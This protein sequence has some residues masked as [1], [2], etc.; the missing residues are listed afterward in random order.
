MFFNF[1]SYIFFE[2]MRISRVSAKKCAFYQIIRI[3]SSRLSCN[4]T[5]VIIFFFFTHSFELIFLGQSLKFELRGWNFKIDAQGI[6]K[7]RR[8]LE[9]F[10][11]RSLKPPRM[12]ACLAANRQYFVKENFKYTTSENEYDGSLFSGRLHATVFTKPAVT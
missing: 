4:K 11:K 2:K 8:S 9:T 3:L 12:G 5:L 7:I 6:Q 1:Y 10:Q